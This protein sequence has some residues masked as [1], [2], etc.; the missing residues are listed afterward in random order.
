ML[1]KKEELRLPVSGGDRRRRVLGDGRGGGGQGE[2]KRKPAVQGITKDSILEMR[3]AEPQREV[4]FRQ[5]AWAG[6]LHSNTHIGGGWKQQ[7]SVA[8]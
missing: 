5:R 8:I 7:Q 1:E 3:F 4:T 6:S 2:A